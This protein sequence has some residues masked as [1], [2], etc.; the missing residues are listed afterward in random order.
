M[1]AS[2]IFLFILTGIV[3]ISVLTGIL[4]LAGRIF[5]R[6]TQVPYKESPAFSAWFA[7]T[8]AML[9][10]ALIPSMNVV[11]ETADLVYGTA[12]GNTPLGVKDAFTAAS[13]TGGIV[14][15][16]ASIWFW[17]WYTISD[18]LVTAVWGKTNA[19]TEMELGNMGY[20]I[21][22]YLFAV[23]CMVLVNP[24]YLSLLRY[25]IPNI[26]IPFYR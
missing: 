6:I 25:F 4:R 14:I 2:C 7:G 19:V 8:T 20:F 10:A 12:T 3:T 21:V 5:H 17:I 26:A 23:L 9:A 1:T 22:R 16:L 13:K 24:F 15:L 11:M 18:Y